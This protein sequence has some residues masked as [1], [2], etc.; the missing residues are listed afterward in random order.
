MKVNSVVIKLEGNFDINRLSVLNF[1]RNGLGCWIFD[2]KM[3]RYIFESTGL[4]SIKITI[5]EK[6][7]PKA[8]FGLLHQITF[9]Q[10]RDWVGKCVDTIETGS[11][12]PAITKKRNDEKTN[13][14]EE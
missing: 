9:R 2:G 11:Y 1:K 14:R 5:R 13:T 3:H 10:I 7:H 6:P 12:L 4:N 8:S